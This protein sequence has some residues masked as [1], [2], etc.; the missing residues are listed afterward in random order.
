MKKAGLLFFL[1]L[2]VSF[3]ASPQT[4]NSFQPFHPMNGNSQPIEA[5]TQPAP[6]VVITPTVD[7]KAA[8]QNAIDSLPNGGIIELTAGNFEFPEGHGIEITANNITIRGQGSSTVITTHVNDNSWTFEIIGETITPLACSNTTAGQSQITLTT[9]AQAGTRLQGVPIMVFGEDSNGMIHVEANFA[10]ADGNASTGVI[11]LTTPL[12]YSLTNVFM[13]SYRYSQNVTLKNFKIVHDSNITSHSLTAIYTYRTTFQN[14]EGDGGGA[15]TGSMS[16]N[17]FGGCLYPKMLDCLAYDYNSIEHYMGTDSCFGFN[18]NDHN[19]GLEATGNTFRNCGNNS[20]PNSFNWGISAA[21]ENCTFSNNTVTNPDHPVQYLWGIGST[22]H[23]TNCHFDNNVIS[24]SDGQLL[25]GF[26]AAYYKNVTFNGNTFDT[27]NHSTFFPGFQIIN[28]AYD[29]GI[30]I[31]NN[32]FLNIPSEAASIG[33]IHAPY[34]V[35]GN[36]V[37]NCGGPIYINGAPQ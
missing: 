2:T 29:S 36:T 37:T 26:N 10:A 6:D 24:H 17:N 16:F 8:L 20:L 21:Q 4:W 35:S 13:R 9:H 1:F 31:K 28:P 22:A 15:V 27:V 5:P 7:L 23:L 32:S 25:Y 12:S 30:E 11:T 19:Y 33:T 34:V 3:C 14:I 18:T